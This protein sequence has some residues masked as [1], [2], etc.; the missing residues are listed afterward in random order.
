MDSHVRP[1]AR[2]PLGWFGHGALAAGL[3][4]MWLSVAAVC[5]LASQAAAADGFCM[6]TGK[7]P[8]KVRQGCAYR[9]ARCAQSQSNDMP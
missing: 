3:A 1:H 2:I 6:A 4:K 9:L 5:L 8:T 7:A